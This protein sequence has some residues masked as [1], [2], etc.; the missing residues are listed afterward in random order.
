MNI[1]RIS[2]NEA[3]PY[4]PA[5]LSKTEIQKNIENKK[6]TGIENKNNTSWQKDI[7]LN[8]LDNLE[9]KIQSANSHPLDNV[10]N[11]PIET[12][13]EALIELSFVNNPIFKEQAVDAQANINPE[14]VLALFLEVPELITQS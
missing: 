1:T 3:Q 14:Q 4:Y 2:T 5:V 6:E 11:A 9:N 7:L 12:H 8:A 10:A 13:D